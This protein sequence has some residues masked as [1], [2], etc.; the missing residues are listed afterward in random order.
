[1]KQLRCEMCGSSDLIKQDG[2]FVC[3]S[4]GCK[5]SVEE[6]RKMMVEVEGTVEVTGTVKVDDSEKKSK[7]LNMAFEARKAGNYDE[8]G[9]YANRVLEMEPENAYAWL[10]KG[11]AV[12]WKSTLGNP[13]IDESIVAWNNTFKYMTAE[14]SLETIG[15]VMST[16]YNSMLQ[17]MYILYMDAAIS[18]IGSGNA[19][20]YLKKAERL[21]DSNV[22][23][24]LQFGLTYSELAKKLDNSEELI[25]NNPFFH[26]T[27][28]PFS[29]WKD[30]VKKAQDIYN[31]SM[32]RDRE[33]GNLSTK[34]QDSL[35]V[36]AMLIFMIHK[37]VGAKDRL[38]AYDLAESITKD[39]EN[40]LARLYGRSS[41]A[42]VFSENYSSI[43]KGRTDAKDLLKKIE[44]QENEKRQKAKERAEKEKE[45][46]VKKYWECHADEKQRLEQEKESEEK[47]IKEIQK[48]IEEI[49]KINQPEIKK[50]EEERKES[51]PSEL[52]QKK[53]EEIQA[54]IAEKRNHCGIFKGKEKKA[55]TEQLNIIQSELSQLREKAK[56]ERLQKDSLFKEK[57]NEIKKE[58]KELAETILKCKSRIAEIQNE[59]TREREE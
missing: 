44:D 51:T 23:T 1:M 40:T 15:S 13:R 9:D 28:F 11:V 57:I 3:Q 39:M 43:R 58:S 18:S 56:E 35:M 36:A 24:N 4:C 42:N 26:Q 21:H 31:R 34:S 45:E 27:D 55:L 25:D 46:R 32:Q 22:K 52:E 49:D 6:A 47:K 48:Q 16:E 37:L 2:V 8:C 29:K 19:D 59:L 7:Y 14:S 17:S 20:S 53:K 38:K 50:L 54:E 12:G 30:T 33:I 5:Y 41:A 10:L